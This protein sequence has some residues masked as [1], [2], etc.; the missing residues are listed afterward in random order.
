[1]NITALSEGKTG[2]APLT[3]TPAPVATVTASLASSSI[4][5]GTT[6][7]ASAVLKDSQNRILS[8]RTITWSSDNTPIA[9]VNQ[10]TGLVTAVAAGTA[11]ITATSEGKSGG[12]SLAVTPVP[13]AAVSVSLAPASVTVGSTSQATAVTRDASNNVLTGRAVTWSSDNAAVAAVN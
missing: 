2:S 7:Q 8:G 10:N 13:V 5:A 1:A 6:T 4:V 3:V 11:T 12:V 9:T